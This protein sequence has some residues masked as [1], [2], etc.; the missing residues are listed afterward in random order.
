MSAAIV[1]L[2]LPALVLAAIGVML[3]VSTLRRPASAP[4]AGFVLRTLGALGLPRGRGCRRRRP[5]VA[6][7]LR[8]RRHSAARPR[9]RVRLGR[10]LP[11]RRTPRRVG[12]EALRRL[13]EQRRT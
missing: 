2:F 8:H 9:V 6:D 10:R 1:T 7:P 12:G 13:G 11:R 4:V 3:L 5:V